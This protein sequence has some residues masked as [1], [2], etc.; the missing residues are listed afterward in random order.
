M[1]GDTAGRT[2]LKAKLR[3]R[4]TKNSDHQFTSGR[5][6]RR[7]VIVRFRVPHTIRL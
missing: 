4:F 3:N 2:V 7:K 1:K 5:G 6:S